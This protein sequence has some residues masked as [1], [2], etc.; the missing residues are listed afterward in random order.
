[1]LRRLAYKVRYEC[2]T[3][4]VFFRGID[5]ESDH[6][7][8]GEERQHWSAPGLERDDEKVRAYEDKRREQALQSANPSF[9]NMGKGPVVKVNAVNSG[10]LR[11]YEGRGG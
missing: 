5:S 4:F 9:S 2:D 8:V 3:D 6:L 10:R 11:P 7:P 1:V